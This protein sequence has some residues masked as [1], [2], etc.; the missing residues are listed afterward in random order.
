MVPVLVSV[1]KCIWVYSCCRVRV[2]L[3]PWNP[4]VS[5]IV[6]P[7]KIRSLAGHRGVY[8][9]HLAVDHFRCP[10]VSTRLVVLVAMC[11]LSTVLRVRGTLGRS[12]AEQNSSVTDVTTVLSHVLTG[13]YVTNSMEDSDN[14]SFTQ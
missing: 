5:T 9:C 4:S 3:G 7:R 11:R 6:L 10:V 12:L 14:R 13:W 8:D 2:S 1:R